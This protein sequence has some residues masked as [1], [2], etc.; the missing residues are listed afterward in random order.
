MLSI[1]FSALSRSYPLSSLPA[2]AH[3]QAV[4]QASDY[5]IVLGNSKVPNVKGIKYSCN[6]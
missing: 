5:G 1:I 4:L 6:M 2:Q 3:K